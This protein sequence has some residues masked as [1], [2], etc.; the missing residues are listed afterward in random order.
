[1]ADIVL[2][3]LNARYH[4]TAFG[5]RYLQANLGELQDRSVILEFGLKESA[6]EVLDAILAESPQIV[7]FGVYIW[8]VEPLTGIVG[9]LKQLRPEI[10]I[11]L[12]GPEVSYELDDLAIADSADFI[13][14]GEADVTFCNVCEQILAGEPP[15]QKVIPAELPQ[16]DQIAMPYALYNDEDLQNR[17]LYVEASRGCPFTCEFCLSA[18]EIPVRQFDVEQFL[19]EMQTL[20]DRGA[21]WF[22]FVDRTFNLNIRIGKQILQFFL[23]RYEPGM[24]LH[25][26]MIPDRLPE[27]LRELIAQFPP[28]ALQFEIGIQT[29][30]DHVSDLISRQQDNE[31]VALN[32]EF[33]TSQP[34]VHIHADL[35]VGLPGEDLTSFGQGFDRLLG[36]N[37]HEIQVGI[38]KRLKGTPIIR[39]DDEWKMTYSPA[40]PYEI[41]ETKL[42]SFEEI[43]RMRRFAQLWDRTANSGNF[44]ETVTL[45]WSDGSPFESFLAFSDWAVAEVGRSHA[46]SLNRL[47]E[48]MFRYLT[49][50]QQQEGQLVAE[51]IWRDFHR[52]GRHDKPKFLRE[53]ELPTVKDLAGHESELP[54]LPDRQARHA[55]RLM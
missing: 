20:Y 21:R 37:P 4:H 40:P 3:T 16:L 8:N 11:I 22:K 36:M 51:S 5:L 52:A 23:D 45:L 27:G 53:F 41:L 49:E 15:H 33:L 54:D 55:G 6:T 35:I 18:L 2:T 32:F 30:N 31:K 47:V 42:V 12:G 43:Q 26:E 34:G 19:G 28:G 50:Q 46:I 1:M 14:Q 29:F 7:G 44:V 13:I 38:L 9:A 39:H 17:V 48:L 24:F 25:F 10:T